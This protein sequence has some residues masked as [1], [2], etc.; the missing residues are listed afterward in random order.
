MNLFYLHIGFMLASMALLLAGV[1]VAMGFRRKRW[2]L[3]VHRRAGIGA[4]FVLLGGFLAAILLVSQ[5]AGAHF[6][7]P[8][9]WLGGATLLGAFMTLLLG[10]SSFRF[11]GHAPEIRA[12]HRVSGRLTGAMGLITVLSGLILIGVL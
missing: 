2:W 1:A 11:P 12:T 8:H 5:S 4:G 7:S 6:A 3:K 9:T 10:L